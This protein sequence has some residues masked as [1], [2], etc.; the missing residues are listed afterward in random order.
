MAAIEPHVTGRK[1]EA[2]A[3]KSKRRRKATAPG[4]SKRKRRN[5]GPPT[6]AFS[7]PEFCDAHRISKAQYYLLKAQGLAPVEM[8]VG[9]RRIIS[10]EAAAQWRREREAVNPDTA[11]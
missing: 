9:G 8:V 10:Y 7:V 5:R 1:P 3:L 2:I 6:H 4:K 11:A